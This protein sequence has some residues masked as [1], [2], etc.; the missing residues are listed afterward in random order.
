M[1]G[2]LSTR[3]A[4]TFAFGL[5]LSIAAFAASNSCIPPSQL[6]LNVTVTSSAPPLMSF[7]FVENLFVVALFAS[8]LCTPGRSLDARCAL[9]ILAMIVARSIQKPTESTVVRSDAE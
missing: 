5:A 1:I 3:F 9:P 8:R 7:P 6:W 2:Y 4:I